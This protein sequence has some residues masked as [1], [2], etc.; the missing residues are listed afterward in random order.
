MRCGYI[1]ATVDLASVCSERFGNSM[2]VLGIAPLGYYNL[3]KAGK[4]QRSLVEIGGSSSEDL[5]PG[6]VGAKISCGG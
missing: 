4:S 1:T 3:V 5:E 2:A 6:L